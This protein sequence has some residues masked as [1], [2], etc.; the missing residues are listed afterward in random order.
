METK[1]MPEPIDERLQSLET[2]LQHLTKLTESNLLWQRRFGDFIEE[3]SP[4]AKSMMDTGI[5]ELGGLE[6]QGYFRFG[7]DLMEALKR[8]AE[9]YEPGSL[10]DLADAFADVVYI[11]RLF[12]QPRVLAA[13]QDL[14]EGFQEADSKPVEMLGATKRIETER[15][16]QRGIAFALDLFGTLGRSVS[17]AP[18][19]RNARKVP[20]AA[21]VHLQ[22]KPSEAS[23][24]PVASDGDQVAAS[25]EFV[26]VSDQE[27]NQAWAVNMAKSLGFD[28]LTD[29]MWK[30]VEFSRKEYRDT[31]KAPNIRRITK[32][33]G[34]STKDVYALFPSAPGPTISRLAGIP[35]PAGCL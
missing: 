13:A 2:Q 24:R 27:W 14:A 29:A 16:I 15:D 10:P 4:V 1:Q 28:S 35:K 17:R 26:V 22:A 33:L 8:V 5:Q 11:L 3:M 21:R 20:K 18:R 30:I 34:I 6:R 9:G 25:T 31:T 32:A 23:R 19:L 7:S 12:S